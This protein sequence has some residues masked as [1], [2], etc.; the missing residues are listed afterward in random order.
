MTFHF[1]VIC[2]VSADDECMG[3]F[4]YDLFLESVKNPMDLVEILSVPYFH[5]PLKGRSL[6]IDG[7][8]KKMKV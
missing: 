1:S 2:Q 8:R 6:I 3:S 5:N 4:P 7:G